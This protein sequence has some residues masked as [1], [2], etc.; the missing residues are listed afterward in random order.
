[1]P[2]KSDPYRELAQLSAVGLMLVLST[3]IGTGAG[4][5]LDRHFHTS[6]A[7]TAVGFLLGTAAGFVEL[8]RAAKKR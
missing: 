2:N 3:A 8:F 1:M 7:L 4:M 5:W 6:P